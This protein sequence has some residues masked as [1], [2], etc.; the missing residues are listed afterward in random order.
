M[1]HSRSWGRRRFKIA[2]M[3]GRYPKSARVG[4]VVLA[5]ADERDDGLIAESFQ[6]L[7]LSKEIGPG[8]PG[9]CRRPSRDPDTRDSWSSSARHNRNRPRSCTSRARRNRTRRRIAGRRSGTCPWK[10]PIRVRGSCRLWVGC[11]GRQGHFEG[12][13]TRPCED[14]SGGR[15]PTGCPDRRGFCPKLARPRFAS[16]SGTLLSDPLCRRRRPARNSH[17]RRKEDGQRL[18]P[19]GGA[20]DAVAIEVR[21]ERVLHERPVVI[22][23]PGCS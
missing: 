3:T 10:R 8:V 14:R 20:A 23:G 2:A 6:H 4:S 21:E 5:G 9:W 7:E 11:P 17:E 15:G 16:T 22:P 19:F 18:V 1:G 13:S 12:R